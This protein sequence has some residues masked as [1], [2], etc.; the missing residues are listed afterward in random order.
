MRVCRVLREAGEACSP[1]TECREG[2]GAGLH[3]QDSGDLQ[4]AAEL[5]HAPP[6]TE[7][8]F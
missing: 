8:F 7:L 5:S 2:G 3:A 4:L 6:P 1:L